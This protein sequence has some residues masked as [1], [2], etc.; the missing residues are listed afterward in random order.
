M[1]LLQKSITNFTFVLMRLLPTG[2]TPRWIILI[3]DM[4]L[5]IFALAIA[6]AIRFDFVEPDHAQIEQE[7]VVLKFALPIYLI[8]RFLSFYI[9]KTYSGIIRF[10]STQ[11]A[12]RMFLTLALGTV[13]F[14]IVS[15]IR[16]TFID[17]Y[18]L[19][20]LSILFLEFILSFF[21]LISMRVSIKL[22][23]LEQNKSRGATKNVVI[24]GAGD[25]GMATKKILE[26]DTEALFN[27]IGFIDDNSTLQGK[28][29]ERTPVKNASYLEKWA[30]KKEIDSVI[31]AIKNP[32]P[33]AKSKI[34]DLCLDLN[35]D[36]L[37]VPP[38]EQWMNGGFT[39]KQIKKVK[40]E[41]LLGRKEIQLNIKNV[42]SFIQGKTILIT[43]GAGSIG[44]EIARQALKFNP[45][46]LILLDQAESPL[47]D[48]SNELKDKFG[49]AN[50]ELLIADVSNEKRMRKAF[51]HFRPQ[52]VFHAAA[53]KHVPM[54]EDNP[55]E[56]IKVNV[57]G[58]KI[59][60]DLSDEFNV[61]SFVM[62]STDKAVNPTNVMGA[63]KRIAEIYIQSLSKHSKTK[64]TTTRFGNV[65]G[66]NGSVIPL[67]KRQIENGGP[68]TVT[69]ERITRFFM[70]IP[71]ACQLVLEA[72][73]MGN[74]GEIFVFDMGESIKIIDLAKKMVKLS[75]LEIDKDIKIKITGLRPGEKLYE[76]LLTTEENTI[77]THHKKIM[78]G[79][80]KEYQLEKVKIKLQELINLYETQ[81]ND[82]IV[83]K[84]KEIV[85][86]FVSNN[87][88]FSKFDQ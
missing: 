17:G 4:L 84:M 31:I 74:G 72:G 6:Y 20:P 18:F 73:T 61:E 59:L 43:G 58:S 86:E 53:Y 37:T 54:M 30:N 33:E 79:K 85:P 34:I 77:P 50:F 14:G 88:I 48:L 7:W 12:K 9:S 46:Q 15:L 62:I 78:I 2:N 68:I 36:L 44:S 3:V 75:G 65:L 55:S 10:T 39:S 81:D 67:F 42:T 70:T 8:V 45:K 51:E 28:F 57:N 69:D 41:D 1:I 47:Y 71:E 49:D 60:A 26:Q 76:E 64:F 25:M 82:L 66:S 22:L 32:N 35:I 5:C 13:I 63:S 11:D 40:I 38:L 56:A 52:V 19:L 80:V 16:H 24:Y 23:Y 27:I 83:K 87:S 29:L 21:L